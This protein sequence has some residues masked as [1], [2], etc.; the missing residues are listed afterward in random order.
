[1]FVALAR[2]K[3]ERA[4]S[5]GMNIDSLTKILKMTGTNDSLKIRYQQDRF[6]NQ[7]ILNGF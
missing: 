1:M 4:V 5:L 7:G 2:F 3:C 6:M